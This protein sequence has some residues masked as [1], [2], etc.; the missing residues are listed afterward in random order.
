MKNVLITGAGRGIGSACAKEFAAAGWH[1][2]INYNKSEKEA[3]ALSQSIGGTAV[4]ADITNAEDVAK[5]YS[6]LASQ[7]IFID[8]LVNNAGISSDKLFIDISEQEWDNV[9]DVNVK[10]TFLVTKA[11]LPNMINKKSGSIINISSIWG[12]I[13]AAGEVHYSASKS[14]VIGMTKA[15]A[16]ELAPSNIRV[17]CICPGYID[18]EMNSNYTSQEVADITDEI[19]LG[20]IGTIFEVAKSVVFLASDSSSYITGQVLGVNGGWNI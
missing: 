12:E 19:P 18:T 8:C 10:G 3:L 16:K 20:R 9:F 14:A 5:M 15:L 2:V 11:F 7:G 6:H 4:R 13:G 17:N 1:V